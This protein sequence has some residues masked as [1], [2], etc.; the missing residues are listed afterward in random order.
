MEQ[1]TSRRR[2]EVG[3]LRPDA[4]REAASGRGRA[5]RGVASGFT[6]ARRAVG[7]LGSWLVRT[8]S[9]PIG[10]RLERQREQDAQMLRRYD[11]RPIR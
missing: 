4:T 7:R 11:R 5:V 9:D 8:A 1:V 3:A 10:D 2:L 6:H